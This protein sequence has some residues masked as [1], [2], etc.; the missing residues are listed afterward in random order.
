MKKQLDER[1]M[2][3]A[4]A[5]LQVL[6]NVNPA[7]DR[8]QQI[9][10]VYQAIDKAIADLYKKQEQDLAIAYAALREIAQMDASK[11]DLNRAINLANGVLPKHH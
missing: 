11:D 2:Q 6:N 7:A 9:Q 4:R 5:C 3:V 1:Y 10:E 8:S